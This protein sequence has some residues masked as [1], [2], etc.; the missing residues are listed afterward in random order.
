MRMKILIGLAALALGAAFASA[1]ASAY[2][3]VPGYNSRGGVIA[4]HHPRHHTLNN[5]GQ[6]KIYNS[7]TRRAVQPSNKADHHRP[8]RRPRALEQ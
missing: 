3:A 8:A 6:R 4:I 5:T 7:E 2:E 1:P